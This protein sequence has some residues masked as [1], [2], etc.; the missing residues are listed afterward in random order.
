MRRVFGEPR[1]ECSS[2]PCCPPPL[3]PYRD[4]RLPH[5]AEDTSLPSLPATF[6][7][8]VSL[9][10]LRLQQ[11]PQ[12]GKVDGGGKGSVSKLGC[13]A[14]GGWLGVCKGGLHSFQEWVQACP[15]PRCSQASARL[16]SS[17]QFAEKRQVVRIRAGQEHRAEGRPWTPAPRGRDRAEEA[18]AASEPP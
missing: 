14:L 8:S 4:S 12:C 6:S 16:P 3:F 5:S 10:L 15:P 18:S 7:P 9:C 11:R 17:P 1:P 2:L 13:K